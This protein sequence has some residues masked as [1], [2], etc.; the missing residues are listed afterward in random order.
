ME[1]TV[2]ELINVRNHYANSVAVRPVGRTSKR[3]WDIV[4]A[5]SAVLLLAPLLCL[6][7]LACWFDSPGPVIYRHRR[8]GFGGKQFNCFKFR[9]MQVNSHDAF[10]KYLA[11]NPSAQAEWTVSRKLQ[12]DP[13]VTAFGRILRKTSLDE[14]PQLFNVLM[15]D[16]S[17]VGPRP[18]TM[19]ELD[20]YSTRVGAYLACRPGITGLWQISGRSGTS[21]SKRVACDAFYAQNWSLALDVKIM[22]VTLPVLLDSQNAY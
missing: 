14:L 18:V 20:R 6:C 13:R 8:V 1:R 19:D 3:F 16:M 9:T 12:F 22:L 17:I 15:G 5:S 2:T 4:L 21:Y 11:T 7:F 10:Q